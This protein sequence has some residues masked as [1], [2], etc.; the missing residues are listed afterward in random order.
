MTEIPG[1]TSSDVEQPDL[2]GLDDDVASPVESRDEPAATPDG[3][4][5]GGLAGQDATSGSDPMPD[6]GGTSTPPTGAS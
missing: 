3:L 6:M 2:Q 4:N 5:L 1:G